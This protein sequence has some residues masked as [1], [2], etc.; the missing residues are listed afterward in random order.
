LP[1]VCKMKIKSDLHAG[2]FLE[3]ASSLINEALS[4]IPQFIREADAE[5]AQLFQEAAGSAQALW[6][7]ATSIF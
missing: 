3:D 4:S 2:S 6:G 5:A 7:K 1:L